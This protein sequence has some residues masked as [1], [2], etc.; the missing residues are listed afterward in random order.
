MT[1]KIMWNWVVI[2]VPM[3]AMYILIFLHLN[4]TGYILIHKMSKEKINMSLK[5]FR[6]VLKILVKT[7]IVYVYLFQWFKLKN[8]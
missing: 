7:I 3:T 8:L 2:I 6:I 4:L 5:I 1:I